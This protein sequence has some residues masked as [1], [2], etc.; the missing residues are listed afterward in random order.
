MLDQL[1]ELT[2]DDQDELRALLE[3]HVQR[4][5]STVAQGIL[6][7]FDDAVAEFVKIF[8]TDFKRVLAQRAAAAGTTGGAA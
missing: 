1:E 3:E 4:T 6:D 7:R 2:P 8:P 5:G